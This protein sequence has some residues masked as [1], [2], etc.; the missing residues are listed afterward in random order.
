LQLSQVYGR[1]GN[2]Q[3]AQQARTTFE[4]L[5]AKEVEMKDSQRPRT[6]SP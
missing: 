2:I 1:L 4:K 5:H 6:F 3:E